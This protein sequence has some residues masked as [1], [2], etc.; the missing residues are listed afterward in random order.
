MELSRG[1]S[2]RKVGVRSLVAAILAAGLLLR[3][4]TLTILLAAVVY[5]V[6]E[7]LHLRSMATREG[8]SVAALATSSGWLLRSGFLWTLV[9]LAM[10][11][12]LLITQKLVP[13]L[14]AVSFVYVG[15]LF[16]QSA[17]EHRRDESSFK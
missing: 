17:R 6:A 14:V 11:Y 9:A 16:A 12:A 13:T 15:G 1:V 4:P 3:F 8:A 10:L 5:A 2:W 7:A